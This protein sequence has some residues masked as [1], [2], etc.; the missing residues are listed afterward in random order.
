MCLP[1][2]GGNEDFV[3]ELHVEWSSAGW[4]TCLSELER[5]STDFTRCLLGCNVGFKND[6]AGCDWV[7][8]DWWGA[9]ARF[10]HDPCEIHVCDGL[11]KGFDWVGVSIPVIEAGEF[12]WD[13]TEGFP[14]LEGYGYAGCCEI[15]DGFNAD[16]S[17]G[18]AWL[19][20]LESFPTS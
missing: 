1:L 2:V 6:V 18:L 15:T 10:G 19:D 14:P 16:V 3:S 17:L 8:V 20:T 11:G 12:L 7:F 5:Y 9:L 13:C 4:V